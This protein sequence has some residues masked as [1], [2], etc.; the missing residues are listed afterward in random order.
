MAQ[1]ALGI[2]AFRHRKI[3]QVIAPRIQIDLAHLGDAKGVRERLRQLGKEGDHLRTAFEIKALVAHL[4]PLGIQN[5]RV[6][7]NSQQE[8]LGV[9]MLRQHIMH[10]VGGDE[11][12]T[13]LATD[14]DHASDGLFQ[15]RMTLVAL[16]LQVK[17]V[18]AEHIA[19]PASGMAR[20]FHLVGHHQAR[21]L[22]RATGRETDDAF[23]VIGQEG[24]VHA[25]SVVKAFQ[26]AGCGNQHQVLITDVVFGQ[27]H[28][29]VGSAIESGVAVG[30][31]PGGN[32][33]LYA[34]DGFHPGRLAGAVE[35]NDAIHHTVV[36]E[37]NGPL[38]QFGGARGQLVHAAHAVQQ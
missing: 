27:K 15:F 5:S 19:I 34:D 14:L 17:V 20:L 26:L 8:L 18:R 33:H 30:H 28:Q 3:G 16:E 9:G 1:V 36:S 4:H 22:A 29:M 23:G 25:G 7:L 37:G 31:A 21:D 24:F 13:Q 10:V 38:A 11:R 2:V 6:G 32:V 12:D 35:L